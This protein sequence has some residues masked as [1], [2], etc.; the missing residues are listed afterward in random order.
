MLCFALR[1]SIP[2]ISTKLTAHCDLIMS[3]F[4]L[5]YNFN[6]RIAVSHFVDE[7]ELRFS[8]T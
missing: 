5:S 2:F 4:I 3:T 8:N 6:I 7:F 1:L